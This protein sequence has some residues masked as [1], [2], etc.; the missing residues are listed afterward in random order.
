MRSRLLVVIGV[1]TLV[2]AVAGLLKLTGGTPAESARP[3]TGTSADAGPAPRTAWGD[4]DLQGIWTD[5]YQTP[6]QRPPQFASK[7]LFTEEERAEL[8]RQRAGIP[9]RD[10]RV[11]RGSE[12][13][14]AGAYNAVFQSVRPTGKRTSLVVDPPDGRIPA[15]T[16]E[17]TKRN[18]AEREYRLALLQ[19]TE[20]C[21]NKD[22]ACAGGKYG[23]VSPRRNGMPP[24]YNTGRTNRN[25]GPEDR[26]M[27]ER[28]MGAVLPDFGGYRRIVQSP[29]S[30]SIFYDTGQGQGWQRIIPIDERPH[31]PSSVRQRFG[32]SRGRWDGDTLV[33]DVTNFSP[34]FSYQAARENLHLIERFRRVDANTIE[35]SVVIEDPSTWTKPWTVKQEFVRQDEQ[36]NRIYY[37]PRCHEGN[38]G[39]PTML[40]GTRVEEGAFARGEGPDPATKDTA[41]DF[42]NEGGIDALTG[43]A[44]AIF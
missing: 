18:E 6:L 14:V 2:V 3:A 12:R 24:F 34:K 1:A 28:C 22:A 29:G 33:V 38:Y 44:G 25:D 9:R 19:A 43:A 16:A 21:K 26:S 39:L 30:V 42:G 20:T 36:A 17:A 11:E 27:T 13:D 15:L 8:D 35:Y 5:P 31:L 7:E 32:D 23:P 37:E 4:P 40:L 10:Q 41:T